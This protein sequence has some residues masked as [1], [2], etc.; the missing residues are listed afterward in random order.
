M[1]LNIFCCGVLKKELQQ[2]LE[3]ITPVVNYRISY[4]EPGLHVD[5]DRLA[6]NVKSLLRE[7]ESEDKLLLLGTQCH[8]ELNTIAASYKASIPSAGNCIEMLLGD[9]KTF[10]DQEAKTFYLTPGWLENWR[11]IFIEG[12]GWDSVDA[13]QNFGLYE[14]ILLLD[15]DVYTIEDE[16]ILEFFD[17]TQVPVETKSVKLDD[18]REIIRNFMETTAL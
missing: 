2:V 13:R 12:L 9:K 18:F 8:P 3:D 11:Q 4:L 1:V 14:R 5:M 7:K 10:L 15:T 6:Q 16:K 17:Y